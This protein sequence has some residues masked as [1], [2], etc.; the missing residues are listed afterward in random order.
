[1]NT[2]KKIAGLTLAVVMLV[3]MLAACG[4]N[5]APESSAPIAGDT[6]ANSTT[7]TTTANQSTN[8]NTGTETSSGDKTTT[9]PSSASSSSATG[10]V[11]SVVSTTTTSRTT[12]TTTQAEIKHLTGTEVKDR[13]TQEMRELSIPTDSMT[14]SLV[15]EGNRARL[16][17]VMRRA[18]NGEPITIG[19]IGGSITQ[20]M[21]AT[22]TAN[23]YA[24]RVAE[25]WRETFPHSRITLVNAGIGATDSV[26]GV[27]RVQEHLL[28]KKPDFIIV[29]YSVNDANSQ[30]CG[31][32]YEN[33]VRRCL[34]AENQPAVLLLHMMDQNGKNVQELHAVTGEHYQLPMISYRDGMLPLLNRG[35]IKWADISPDSIHPNDYGHAITALFVKNYLAQVYAELNRIKTPVPEIPAPHISDAYE[36]ATLLTPKN[37]KAKSLGSFTVDTQ[38][39]YSFP[40]GWTV[41]EGTSPL[42]LELKQVKRVFVLYACRSRSNAGNAI[43]SLQGVD[44]IKVTGHFQA[45]SDQA[46]TQYMVMI[47]EDVASNRLLTV[48]PTPEGDRTAFTVLGVM[49]S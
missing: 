11:G 27:H 48:T 10:G 23:N 13:V 14:K 26:L 43:L 2:G 9:A 21:S 18:M 5:P 35:T 41:N 42:Q 3:G 29:E 36:N 6:S 15:S 45:D 44:D 49:V 19:V 25:W 37:F 40:D 17:A 1:M 7:E 33:L 32:A 16:A 46:Y 24:S 30:L 39:F 31:E 22:G 47:Y 20:G 4:G 34:K 12:A 8:Q 38:A 28:D